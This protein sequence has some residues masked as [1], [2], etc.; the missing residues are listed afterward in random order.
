MYPEATDGGKITYIRGDKKIVERIKGSLHV[1]IV[2]H[3]FPK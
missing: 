3:F 1:E 2:I